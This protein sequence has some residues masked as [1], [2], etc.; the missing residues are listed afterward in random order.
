MQPRGC[1]SF[2]N[3]PELK[4]KRK[5]RFIVA[6]SIGLTVIGLVKLACVHKSASAQV[7]ANTPSVVESKLMV[8]NTQFSFKLFS[9]ILKQQPNQNIFISPSSITLALAMTYNGASGETQEA[10]AKTLQLQEISIQEINQANA[11]LKASLENSD[12]NVQL[13][14]ANSFWANETQPFNP[15]FIETIKRFYGAEVKNLNFGDPNSVSTINNWVKQNTNGKIDTIVD[16]IKPPCILL[17][18]IYFLGTWKYPFSQDETRN[19]PFN[20]LDGTHKE[21]PM[22]FQNLGDIQYYKND[23]FQA[24]SLPYGEEKLSMYIFLPNKEISLN[25]FYK[26]LNA[27]N[28]QKWINQFHLYNQ[29]DASD[30]LQIGLPRFKVEYEIKLNDALKALGMQIAFEEGADFSGIS[31]VPFWIELVK[32][33]TFVEVNEE[34]TEAAA[35]TLVGSTRGGGRMIVDRPFFFVIRDNQTGTILF[36]GSIVEPDIGEAF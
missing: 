9:E 4:M 24:V 28:W 12:P 27:E 3:E 13:S 8:A 5:N 14:I 18:A 20:L 22:M 19:Y 31:N 35:V 30:E 10:I 25:T 1:Q 11:A 16:Q 33:K 15:Q 6:L 29:L 23:K 32:H 7:S 26:S 36:M 2:F 21:H 17:N 34:G